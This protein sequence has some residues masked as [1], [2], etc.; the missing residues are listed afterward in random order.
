MGRLLLPRRGGLAGLTMVPLGV[1]KVHCS[2]AVAF[3][4]GGGDATLGGCEDS[5]PDGAGPVLTWA[6]VQ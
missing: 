5:G 6:I 2:G 1:W 4:V 3:A